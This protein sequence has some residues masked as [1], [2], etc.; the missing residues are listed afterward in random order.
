MRSAIGTTF[1]APA[2]KRRGVTLIELMVG[3][4]IGMLAVLVI[5]QVLLVSEGQKRS[6]TAGA[7]AQ[8]NGALSLYSIQRD[9]QMAGYGF[10][11]SPGIVGCTINAQFNGATPAQF[12]TTLTP[13]LITPAASRPLGSVG[14]SVRVLASSKTSF[15]VPTRVIPPGIILNGQSVPVAASMGFEKGDLGLLATSAAQPCWVFQVTDIPTPMDVPRVD[16]PARWNAAGTPAQAYGD[17]SILVNLGALID[18]RYEIDVANG[19]RVLQVLSFDV[20]NPGTPNPRDIQSDIVGL[21]AYYGRDTSVARD[22]SVD[23]YDQNTP[24]TNDGWSRVLS[25]RLLVVSRSALYEKD[26]VTSANPTWDVGASPPT[27][28]S[29]ACG[30]SQCVTIDV[31]AGAA[32]DARH[33]RYKVFETIVPLRNLLWSS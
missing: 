17:G 11:S 21:R 26:E 16:Q 22:G 10:S 28:G 33:Y 30:A 20:A 2:A 4:L 13:V 1:H 7:D 24:T 29:A 8:V 14:D 15:T 19:R 5:S 6:T 25:V 27:A 3:V 23:I 9:V 31:G 32:G 12:P 18:N